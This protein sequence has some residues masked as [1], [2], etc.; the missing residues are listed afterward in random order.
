MA[1][2]RKPDIVRRVALV[3][4]FLAIFAALAA[5]RH[6]DTAQGSDPDPVDPVPAGTSMVEILGETVAVTG[7]PTTFEARAVM[8]TGATVDGYEWVFSDGQTATGQ[9]VSVAFEQPGLVEIIVKARSGTEIAG[10]ATSLVNVFPPAGGPPP[11]EFETLPQ[12]FGDT[13]LNGSLGLVDALLAAQAAAGLVTIDSAQQSA[14]DIDISTVIDST[15]VRLI[16]LALL[17]DAPLPDA[18]IDTTGRP[19]A[20]LSMMSPRLLDPAVDASITVDGVASPQTLR[21]VLGFLTYV[22]PPT[23]VGTGEDVDVVLSIGGAPAVTLPLQLQPL[24]AAALPADA[25]ADVRAMLDELRSLISLQERETAGL[26]SQL[27]DLTPEAR[28]IVLAGSTGALAEF[29]RAAAELEALLNGP[30][31]DALAAFLQSAFYS[32]GLDEFRS[33]LAALTTTSQ[34]VRSVSPSAVCD[35]VIPSVCALKTAANITSVGSKIVVGS[36]SVASLAA[37][38]GGFAT[39]PAAPAVSGAALAA[40]VKICVPLI[41]PMEFAGVIADFIKPVQPSYELISDKAS[42][43]AN[44][45]AIL[46]TEVSFNGA[47]LLCEGFIGVGTN[48]LIKKKLGERVVGLLMT[49]SSSMKVL[50]SLF[51]KLGEDLYADLLGSVADVVGTTLDATGLGDAYGNLVTSLCNFLPKT[52]GLLADASRFGL[53]ASNGGLLSFLPDGTASLQCPA[54]TGGMGPVGT[55]SVSSSYQMCSQNQ[56]RSTS[57]ACGSGSVTITM[58]DNGTANDD[59]YEV[60]IDGRTVLTSNTPVRSTSVTVAL[61]K[62]PATVLMRGRAA[63]DGIGT[64]FIDFG[65]ATV[66]PGSAPLSGRDLTPG[67]TKTFLIEVL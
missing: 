19:G 47:G 22:V 27:Q 55:I 52:G 17:Q 11:A 21:P 67:V 20:V 40:F 25:K 51:A 33:A 35:V 41:V 13:D 9:T 57:V 24:S 6:D 23:L 45:T 58:G 15:D 49:R 66:L 8:Q 39:G 1:L 7:V 53:A 14:A 64:Y 5:C 62:G 61:P 60:V 56:S 46:T 44:E 36:C 50:G 32:N 29:D 30:D 63:P 59:I 31:G 28:A 37:V 43:N 12:V 18:L 65:G 16:A 34:G 3:G 54:P 48:D 4:L 38:V 2:L 10:D 26:M 42:L